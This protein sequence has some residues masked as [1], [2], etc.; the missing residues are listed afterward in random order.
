MGR[1]ARVY[2]EQAFQIE[3]IVDRFEGFLGR[4]L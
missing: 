2:A 3:K 4:V 1:K